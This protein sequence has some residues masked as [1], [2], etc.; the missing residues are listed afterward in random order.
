MKTQ[1]TTQLPLVCTL[2]LAACSDTKPSTTN[3]RIESAALQ[4][5]AVEEVTYGIKVLS[6]TDT[7]WEKSGITS[8]QYGDGQSAISYIGTCD[9]TAN[10]HTVELTIENVRAGGRD[11]VD[12]TDWIN[13]APAGSPIRKINITCV[14]NADVPVVFDLTVMRSA[15]QGFF[16]IGVEFDD[17]FCSAKLDCDDDLL[18]N[19]DGERDATAI[20]TFACSA[21][22][23][24]QTFVYTSDVVL[25]C[26]DGNVATAPVVFTMPAAG[27]TVGQQGPIV[28]QPGNVTGVFQWA[29]YQGQEDLTSDGAPI[30]KCFWNRAV[31]IDRDALLAAGFTS[32]RM[33]AAGTASDLPLGGNTVPSGGAY[34]IVSYDVEVWSA[35]NGLCSNNP[36]NGDGSGVVTDYVT[37]DTNLAELMPLTGMLACGDGASVECPAPYGEGTPLAVNEVQGVVTIAYGSHP[38]ATVE[39][40]DGYTLGDSCCA[41]D[42]C[43]N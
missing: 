36:L 32:C 20:V 39:L 41:D 14:E 37:P 22:E 5:D 30:E 3:F 11:L 28:G 29:N 1:L 42:C 38:P 6:A 19:A 35:A 12:P 21:G 31:G 18:H 8:T 43:G 40:P 10:P 23:E 9:A 24:E 27:A 26:D 16:D 2:A 4:L 33:T 34:P 25:T 13:P 15:K 17:I 7:V